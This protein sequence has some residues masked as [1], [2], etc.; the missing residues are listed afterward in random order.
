MRN[1]QGIV[2]LSS[3]EFLE[4][5]GFTAGELLDIHINFEK[6]GVVEL[7]MNHPNLPASAEGYTL[8]CYDY[9]DMKDKGD[10]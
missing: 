7:K 4:V 1:R 9:Q 10:L 2:T 3:S 8:G 6:H 5:M